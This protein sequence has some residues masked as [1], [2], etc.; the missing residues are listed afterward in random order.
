[1]L[2][3]RERDLLIFAMHDFLMTFDDA[4]AYR[5]CDYGLF[6]METKYSILECSGE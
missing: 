4:D 2:K 6:S 3:G 5:R 1:M